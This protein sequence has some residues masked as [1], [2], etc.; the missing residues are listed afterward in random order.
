[1]TIIKDLT[2]MWS[3]FLEGK[4]RREGVKK[5]LK[6][7]WLK[8]FQI[9]QENINLQT[10]TVEQI[11][12]RINSKKSTPTYILTKLLKIK[13]KKNTESREKWHVTY[14]GENYLNNSQYFI[15]N[16]RG[17]KKSGTFLGDEKKKCWF[18]ILCPA[19][20]SLR[21][22]GE[23]KTFSDG[24]KLMEFVTS[25]STLKEWLKNT[26]WTKRKW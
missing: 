13:T 15:R 26:F 1:M 14:L 20:I 3:E 21:N 8:N 17:Q 10:R 7:Q 2:I 18:R 11:P 6:T 22:K 23:I 4:R 12:N 24:R 16:H 19:K 9:L 25:R 5:Y